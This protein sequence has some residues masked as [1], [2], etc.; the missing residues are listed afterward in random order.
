MSDP[1]QDAF[2]DDD[3]VWGRAFHL[4]FSTVNHD[5]TTPIEYYTGIAYTIDSSHEAD[6][7]AYLGTLLTLD[8]SGEGKGSLAPFNSNVDRLPRKSNS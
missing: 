8:H 5:R 1:R 4:L 7:R 3:I 6:V 2:P